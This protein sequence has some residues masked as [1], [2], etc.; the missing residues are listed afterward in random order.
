VNSVWESIKEHYNKDWSAMTVQDWFGLGVTIVVFLIMIA[1]YVYV[2]HPSN[3]KKLEAHRD[4][5]LKEDSLEREE[6]K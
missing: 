2:F 6:R 4:I 3:K 1:L 5:P